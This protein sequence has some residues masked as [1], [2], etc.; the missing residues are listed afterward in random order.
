[1]EES[2]HN[3][4]IFKDILM[5]FYSK[6]KFKVL[7]IIILIIIIII[8]VFL[9]KINYQK[10]NNFLAREY[11]R[12]GILLTKGKNNESL[13]VYEKIILS[14]NKFYSIL[15]LNIIL[16][17]SL[18]TEPKKILNYFDLVQKAKIAREQKNLIILKKALYLI[19]I[20]KKEDGEKLLK[21]LVDKDSKLKILAEEIIEK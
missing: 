5:S 16:E 15:A 2:K 19:K 12:A 8:T 13:E 11:V 9:F 14:K 3:K 18:E 21:N 1:M 10:E 20:D 4:T 6:N 17:K 7:A